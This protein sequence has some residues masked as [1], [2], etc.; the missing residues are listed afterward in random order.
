MDLPVRD[1]DGMIEGWQAVAR[2]DALTP[3]KPREA[4]AGGRLVVLLRQGDA[5]TAY[6]G[7]CPHQAARLG[8]G[9]IADGWLHCPHHQARFNLADGACG[10]GW[11]LPALQRFATRIED[12]VI[13]L[14]DPL[15]PLE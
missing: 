15:T 10:P 1:E 9:R 2:L 3:G 6:Q 4:L 7:L 12:G 8:F 5:V 14:P 13:L 11:R